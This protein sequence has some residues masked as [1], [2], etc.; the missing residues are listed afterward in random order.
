M[1]RR[2]GLSRI[3][4]ARV[5]LTS[6]EHDADGEDLLGVGVG[7]DV[8]E[9]DA[10]ETAEREVE[11]RD[12]L[13]ADRWSARVVAGERVRLLRLTGQLVQPA[14]RLRQVRPLVVADRVP[15]Q[16]RKRYRQRQP[17][18]DY[19]AQGSGADP[20][21]GSQPAGDVSPKPGGRLPLLSVRPAVTPA[22]LKRA[23]TD[24]AAGEQRHDGCEQFA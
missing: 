18:L 19:R 11:R 10:R 1:R 17:I 6:D 20:A 2:V 16:V 15:A 22:T 9:A 8:A 24:F 5:L 14:D 23:A 12:V 13:G 3:T 21:L 7:R 4:R